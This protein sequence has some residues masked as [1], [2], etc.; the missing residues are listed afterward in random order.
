[1]AQPV[2]G[3][4]VPSSDAVADSLYSFI[5]I[6]FEKPGGDTT[7]HFIL[8]L[9]R[10]QCHGSNYDCSIYLYDRLLKKL[11]TD[12]NL[13][14]IIY[15]LDE[16]AKI[17]K[18]AGQIEKEGNAYLSL[19]SHH[20]AFG[21]KRSAILYLDKA[22]LL[23]Q[24]LGDQHKVLN[25]KMDRL[26]ASTDYQ[27]PSELLDSM[28]VLLQDAIAMKDT[29][30]EE[31]IR[32]R[33][34]NYLLKVKRYDDVEAYLTVLRRRKISN[35]IQRDEYPFLINTNLGFANLAKARGQ[36]DTAI[37]Y[38]KKSLALAEAE[39]GP[40]MQTHMMNILAGIEL[41]QGNKAAAKSYLNKARVLGEKIEVDDLLQTTFELLAQIAEAENNFKDAF[42]YTKLEK[43]Y[44]QKFDE[45]GA[46]FNMQAYLL[47]LEKEKLETE[48]KNKELEL[49]VKSDQLRTSVFAIVFA[50]LLV[51][52]TLIGLYIQRQGKKKIAEQYNLI[53][54]Q[55]E[56]LKSL[57][58]AK[59]RFFANV[60]HELRTPLALIF[61]P[62]KTVLKSGTLDNRNFTILKKAQQSSEDLLKLVASILDLS[63][64]EHGKLKLRES[65]E[66]IFP[67]VQRIVSNFESFAERSG[68][69]LIFNYKAEKNLRLEIDREKVETM[70][71]N[72]LSNAI[73]FTPKGGKVSVTVEDKGNALL[74]VVK[75]TGRG[76][77][78]NDL[79]KIFNRFYQTEE[80]NAPAEGGTG[81]GLALCQELAHLMRGSIKAESTLGEGS[82]FFVEIPRKEVMGT[83]SVEVPTGLEESKNL[84]NEQTVNAPLVVETNKNADPLSHLSTI[85]VVEDNHSLRDY[86][87]TILGI[88]YHV[89]TAENG[90]EALELLQDHIDPSSA[91]NDVPPPS[92]IISDLMMPIMD[93]FQLLDKL[94]SDSMFSHLPVVML[95]ARADI[96]DKLKALRIGVDDYILKPFDDEE[97]MVRIE[98]LLKNQATRNM[99][100]A[101]D[102][103]TNELPTT[104]EEDRLWL[105]GFEAYVDQNI[106]DIQ[107]SVPSLS[108]HFAMSGSSLL[109]QLKRLTGLT[110]AKYLQEIRLEQG[111]QL[112]ETRTYNSIS[113][114]ANEVG[115][116]D[117]RSFSRTFK[118][119]YGKSPSEFLNI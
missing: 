13:P 119:R 80:K 91:D 16:I 56:Q 117:A 9:V 108:E 77:S 110:P 14:A 36:L 26:G 98:N 62:L 46:G 64:L 28:E 38:Y 113:R 7:Y 22:L 32:L 90:K 55:T 33:S 75:D 6:H 34:I 44:Q 41:E 74:L 102:H 42:E 30:K 49:Q 118:K 105:E 97:L 2:A 47:L 89:L 48:A 58:A 63:K 8:Q 61:G 43:H 45:R 35:P 37:F 21:N 69:D 29:L 94:K 1:M 81:I 67:L 115:Y 114:V 11:R 78:Q 52:L 72:L 50:F 10:D 96:K 66:P 100:V 12:F 57:D 65:T 54:Q 99:V 5:K 109:R 31:E 3:G 92:L 95:T 73:K 84:A 17:S 104:S 101:E 85:L 103:E 111:R 87:S 76:I 112:L 60:S 23:F 18:E 70:L 82:T 59:S 93:G 68:T 25:I 53:Q 24:K 40:W 4:D 79:P 71:N 51:A 107:L 116:A 27:N 19:S 88:Q 15:V 106:A 83:S 86:L 20:A 39:P